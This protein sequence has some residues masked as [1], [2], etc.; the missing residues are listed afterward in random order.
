LAPACKSVARVAANRSR[1][2]GKQQ[3]GCGARHG[4]HGAVRSNLILS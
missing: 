4:G 3:S 1:C 2:K